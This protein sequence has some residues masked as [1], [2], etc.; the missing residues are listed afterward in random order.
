MTNPKKSYVNGV[1]VL[2]VQVGIL[3][4][5]MNPIFPSKIYGQDSKIQSFSLKDAQQ[6][7]VLHS[8]D[9]I[10]SLLDVEA[11]KK[12]LKETLAD[13]LP[14]IDSTLGYVN[15]LELPT[16]L[17]PDF[18]SGDFNNKI[19]VQFGT[20]HN[21]NFN[22]TVS[23]KIF[24]VSYF[25]GL[26]TSKIYTQLADQGYE[27]T[28]LDVKETVTNTYFLILVSQES[29]RI[30][31]A[32]IENLE[33][34]LYEISESY[35][36]GF[37]EETEV[38]VIQIS[39]TALKNSLQNVQKQ[40]DVAYKLLNFQMGLD[41]EEKIEVTEKLEDILRRIDIQQ[42]ISAEFDLSQNI[43]YKLL[44]TQEK[45]A[46][47]AHKN[48]KA[49][50][51]PSIS[52]F[53]TLQQVAQR[54][55]FN[56]FNFN[57]DW[58]RSQVFGINIYIPIFKSGGE[59]ARVAQAAI[60]LEQARTA[61]IQA[62]QGILLEDARA[63]NDLTAAYENYLNIK[64]NMELS[65]KVYDTTLIKYREGIA[66]STDLTQANDRYL[67]SQSNYIQAISALLSAKNRLDRIRNTY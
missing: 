52:A 11:A 34:T 16:V 38:N 40:T 32:N 21:A 10:K 20:Q 60:A 59:R 19:P 7:A 26:N 48:A 64:D 47:M 27:R 54:D 25:V 46:E 66:S 41:L 67:L 13:G 43:D 55:S 29:E 35:K 14:Q 65:G 6:F 28:Q 4:L 49:K 31:R 12:K 1:R 42:A 2:L 56:F 62:S 61:R 50:F 18:I 5:G 63:R 8:Y 9:S 17:I 22:I 23:Q 45:L 30:I 37:V 51:W 33:K 57:K 39:V 36:E 53:Y 44:N 3:L 15:N 24:D 58:F